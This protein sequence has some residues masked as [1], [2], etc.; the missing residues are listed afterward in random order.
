M[1]SK[2][3]GIAENFAM[4]FFNGY[5]DQTMPMWNSFK[6][7]LDKFHSQDINEQVIT[8]ADQTFRKFSEWFDVHYKLL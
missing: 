6:S 3:L 5:G 1:L 2:Q 4:S 7:A 8:S